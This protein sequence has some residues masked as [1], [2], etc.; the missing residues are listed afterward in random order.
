MY[1]CSIL[2]ELEA[3]KLVSLLKYVKGNELHS[4]TSRCSAAVCPGRLVHSLRI[5]DE[6]QTRAISVPLYC[7]FSGKCAHGRVYHVNN[8]RVLRENIKKKVLIIRKN[9]VILVFCPYQKVLAYSAQF[10]W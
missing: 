4:C 5:S 10:D 1:F 6:K 9:A 2:H 3:F 7:K 8:M